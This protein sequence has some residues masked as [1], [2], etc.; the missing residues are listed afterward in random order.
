MLVCDIIDLQLAAP[1]LESPCLLELVSRPEVAEMS[2]SA[3]NTFFSG[4]A[5]FSFF[6]NFSFVQRF[7]FLR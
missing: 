2:L 7:F 6:P 5:I 4:F 1:C 3:K